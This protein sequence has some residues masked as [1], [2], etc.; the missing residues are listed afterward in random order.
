MIFYLD[1]DSP[2]AQTFYFIKNVDDYVDETEFNIKFT[3]LG[4]VYNSGV[5][6]ISSTERMLQFEII[7]KDFFKQNGWFDYELSDSNNIIIE[8]NECYIN[9]PIKPKTIYDGGKI[10]KI[11]YNG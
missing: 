3:Q 11:I 9:K 4:N 6:N 5:T 1:Y 10:E 7:T 2:S 8:N